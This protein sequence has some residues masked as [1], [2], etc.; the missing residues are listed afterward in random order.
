[1][2][3]ERIQ[4]HLFYLTLL[5]LL[6]MGSLSSVFRNDFGAKV[7]TTVCAATLFGLAVLHYVRLN[8]KLP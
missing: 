8:T 7:V 4:K 2:R 1:M 6:L 3:P 5:V